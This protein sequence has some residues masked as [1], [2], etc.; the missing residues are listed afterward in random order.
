M[1]NTI[2]E[3]IEFSTVAQFLA[4]IEKLTPG[5]RL[6]KVYLRDLCGDELTDVA[7]EQE[8]LSDGSVV[9]N[10]VLSQALDPNS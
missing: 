7:L 6:D 9:F 5:L 8:T 10:L 4:A 2:L 3:H 1:N